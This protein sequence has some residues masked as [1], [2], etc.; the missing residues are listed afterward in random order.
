MGWQ[1]EAS[2][3]STRQGLMNGEMDVG[4]LEVSV[5]VDS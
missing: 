1:K 2:G 4:D 3:Y 5:S